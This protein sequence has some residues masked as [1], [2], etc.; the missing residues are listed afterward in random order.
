VSFEYRSRYFFEKGIEFL[1]SN[2]VIK[3]NF[4]GKVVAVLSNQGKTVDKGEVLL[5]VE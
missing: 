4:E 1:N 5:L 3:S 2:P